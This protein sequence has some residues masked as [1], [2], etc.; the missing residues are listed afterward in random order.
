MERKIEIYNFSA[1]TRQLFIRLLALVKWAN[2]ASKVDKSAVSLTE[3]F[4]WN[5]FVFNVN[6]ISIAAHH[7]LPGQTI[8]VIC[9]HCRY[10]GKNG[11]RNVSSCTATQLSYSS[12]YWNFDDWNLFTIAGLHSVRYPCDNFF[13][14]LNKQKILQRENRSTR[15]NYT[16]WEET[17]T[18]QTESGHSTSSRNGK[19][20]ATNEEVQ[21][22]IWKFFTFI[23]DVIPSFPDRLRP[24]HISRWTRIRSVA[25]GNGR[26]TE[27]TVASPWNRNSC[28]RQ[29]NWRFVVTFIVTFSFA[30]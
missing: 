11:S 8:N 14:Q 13:F 2:S 16:E 15:S 24:C 21:G 12:G 20:D 1:R 17:D 26:R 4:M 6:A 30:D 29:G 3:I 9:W 19:F 22:K 28:R 7:E 25:N 5:D 27:C 23:V 18:T 10:A